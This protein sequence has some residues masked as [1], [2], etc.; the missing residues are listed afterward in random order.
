MFRPTKIMNVRE[1]IEIEALKRGQGEMNE[2]VVGTTEH[3]ENEGQS[4]S[5][6]GVGNE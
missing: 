6:N 3:S 5:E 1:M 4:G 2:C